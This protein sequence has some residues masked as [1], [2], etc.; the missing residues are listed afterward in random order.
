MKAQASS[1][2]Q[3]ELEQVALSMRRQSVVLEGQLRSEEQA[4][5]IRRHQLRAEAQDFQ[6][7]ELAHVS[8]L[9]QREHAQVAR[10]RAQHAETEQDVL[11][12]QRE[13]HHA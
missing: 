7:R 8:G 9:M 13:M 3:A 5:G 12:E 2:V 6:R 1:Q 11:R 4:V 10:L